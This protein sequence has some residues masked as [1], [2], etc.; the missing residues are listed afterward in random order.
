MFY[1]VSSSFK[2]SLVCKLFK[3]VLK[4]NSKIDI[5][6]ELFWEKEVIS[7]IRR[8]IL[9]PAEFIETNV[10]ES[11]KIEQPDEKESVKILEPVQSKDNESE[12]KPVIWDFQKQTL[13]NAQKVEST[14]STIDF[15]KKEDKDENIVEPSKVEAKEIKKENAPKKRN[16]KKNK[17]GISPVGTVKTEPT[18]ADAAIELDSRGNPVKNTIDILVEGRGFTEGE[19]IDFLKLGRNE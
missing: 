7:L 4:A 5:P 3:R 9:M 17:D 15:D 6:E 8:G 16:S 12:F 11:L 1:K 2:G 18:Q 19:E 14:K 13:E 10:N